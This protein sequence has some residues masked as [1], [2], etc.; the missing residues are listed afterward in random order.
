M[1]TLKKIIT[2]KFNIKVSAFILGFSFWYMVSQSRPL[3]ISYT[4][5][6]IFYGTNTEQLQAAE[7]VTICLKGNKNDFYNLDLKELAIHINADQLKKGK[8]FI[9][10][11]NE[12]LFL[13]QAIKLVHCTPSNVVVVV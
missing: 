4:V 1:D 11:T 12:N 6:L 5:P 2:N 10:V 7:T 3:E 9:Q 8:N 13:P